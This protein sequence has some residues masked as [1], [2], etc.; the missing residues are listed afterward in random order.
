MGWFKKL[1]GEQC[2]G[3]HCYHPDG[4]GFRECCRCDFNQRLVPDPNY[5]GCLQTTTVPMVWI[6]WDYHGDS[7]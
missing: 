6:D 4:T 7:I 5:K 1:I 2:R 3:A